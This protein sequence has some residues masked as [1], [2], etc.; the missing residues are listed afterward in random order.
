MTAKRLSRLIFGTTVALLVCFLFSGDAL[1]D[2]GRG[3]LLLVSGS[4]L[5]SLFPFL[6]LSGLLSATIGSIPLPGGRF[7]KQAFGLPEEGL[8]P[9]LLGALCGFPIGVRI[10]ADLYRRGRITR[11]EAV[12][13]SALSANTGPAFAVAGVGS[14]LFQDAAIGWG[15]YFLQLSTAVL[16]GILTRKPPRAAEEKRAP[17]FGPLPSLS[18][19]L[20]EASLAMLGIAGTVIFFSTASALLT[21]RLSPLI[22]AIVT[23]PLEIGTAAAAAARLPLAAGIP[24]AAFSLSFSGISVL[25][26]SAAFLKDA[27]LPTGP[28][29]KRKLLQGLLSL[30]IVL[31][32]A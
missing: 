29:A 32:F 20:S 23:A 27:G 24:L 21:R 18:S 13:L 17:S 26:Q 7:F 31:L 2:A 10:T 1:L 15:L 12:R 9:F 28:L 14:A 3:A 4:I 11:E 22:A 16:L 5:P 6:V 19:V 25:L 8:I 30:C